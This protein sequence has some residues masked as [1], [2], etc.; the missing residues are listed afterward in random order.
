MPI[1]NKFGTEHPWVNGIQVYSNAG[2][3]HFPWGKSNE[4]LKKCICEIKKILQK[5]QSQF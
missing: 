4:I 5:P 3:R 2:S 1:S